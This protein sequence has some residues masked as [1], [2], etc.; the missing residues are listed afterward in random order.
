MKIATHDAFR[1]GLRKL[2]PKNKNSGS[3]PNQK[4]KIYINCNQKEKNMNHG[5]PLFPT[6]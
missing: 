6:L 1:A 4:E 5:S 2:W 3:F